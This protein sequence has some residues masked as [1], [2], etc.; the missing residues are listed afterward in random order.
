MPRYIVT[1][2]NEEIQ[3]LKTLI[4]KGGKGYRIKHAQILLKLD[5]K[6]ENEAWTYDRIKDA[7]SASRSTI[8]GV[9]QRFVMDG[10]EA[11]L[12]RK[13]QEN[14]RRKVT[15]D[16]EARICAIACSQPPEGASRW[17]MQ[18]IADELIRLEVVDYITDS[19]VCEVMKKNEIKPWLVKEWCIPQADAEFVAK[20]EDVLDVYQRP[21]DPLC[22][23]VCIDET[24]KQL[25]KE[26]RI[27]CGPGQPEKVDSVYIRNGVADVFMISEPLAGRR[28]TVVTKSRTALDFAEILRYTSDILYPRT[29]KIILVTDNLNTHS[30]ASLYKAFEPEEARRLAERF[31]W[32]YTPKHGSWLDMAEIEIG[33]MSRQALWKPLPDMESFQKQVRDWT[34]RRNAEH[35]KI[36]WQFKAKDARI[37]LAKL[38]PDIV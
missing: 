37:K 30:A 36:K 18:A 33:I 28:E 24:S 5:E 6:P 11:A 1:L 35:T 27:P 22:P 23:V 10:L 12:G 17:T 7:Y 20:M 31:E 32:H 16:V 15:G 9:A 38:Y 13:I 8:A 4:Q 3:E 34:V 26:T 19:T 2:T 21:Y 29:E 14:R 25:I